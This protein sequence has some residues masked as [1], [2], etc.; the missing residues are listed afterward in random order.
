MNCP[1]R[2]LV[3]GRE[4]GPD[5]QKAILQRAIDYL[6]DDQV[7]VINAIKSAI[8]DRGF[9]PILRP[10]V[11][12]LVGT[13]EFT[14]SLATRWARLQSKLKDAGDEEMIALQ[15]D[16][17][18][19]YS[20]LVSADAEYRQLVSGDEEMISKALY[21]DDIPQNIEQCKAN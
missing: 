1:S 11:D 19:L 17:R 9:K 20:E 6:A 10:I 5:E 13:I 18:T 21:V 2:L 4:I 16:Q 7:G 3:C 12:E 8:R 14:Y 15:E